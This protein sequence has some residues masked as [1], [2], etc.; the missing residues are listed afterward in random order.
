MML[1]SYRD[2]ESNRS[3][4]DEQYGTTTYF[5]LYARLAYHFLNKNQMADARRALDTFRVR[6]PPDLIDWSSNIQESVGILQETGELYQAAGDS[7]HALQYLRLSAMLFGSSRTEAAAAGTDDYLK[8]EFQIGDLFMRAQLYDSARSVFSGLRS[9]TEGGNQLYV[10]FRLAQIDA[11]VLE[12]HG[13]KR[14]ALDKLNDM[15]TKYAQ[16]ASMGVGQE[17]AN[18]TQ[19][20]DALAKELGVVDTNAN[21]T[22]QGLSVMPGSMPGAAQGAPPP[23][24]TPPAP[25]NQK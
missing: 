20:R 1:T 24:S 15:L 8:N 19:D 21:K 6:M 5:E 12:Q 17:I 23:G 10:D 7:V 16:L 4:L 11:K 13:D 3:G 18:V 9:Q 22:P 2:P 25:G 14:K